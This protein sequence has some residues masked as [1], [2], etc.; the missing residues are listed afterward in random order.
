MKEI[1]IEFSNDQCEV[2]EHISKMCKK[3]T[4]DFIKEALVCLLP[5]NE[6]IEIKRN[7]I[8][9]QNEDKLTE[10]Q[11]AIK[12]ITERIHDINISAS[13]RLKRIGVL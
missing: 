11:K 6:Y 8:V 9:L 7:L 2:L 1:K 3:D 12:E 13:E 4:S 10:N 5:V